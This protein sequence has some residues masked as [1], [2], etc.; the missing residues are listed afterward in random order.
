M[1]ILVVAIDEEVGEEGG[2]TIAIIDEDALH[3]ERFVR[4]GDEDL[5]A[6]A[7]L[8]SRNSRANLPVDEVV[9]GWADLEDVEA[10]VLHHA[11]LVPQ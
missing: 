11:S 5:F 8:V 9:E 4:V 3:G 1:L 7:G 10:L 6:R 2:Q